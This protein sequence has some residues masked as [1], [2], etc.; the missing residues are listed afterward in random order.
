MAGC[1]GSGTLS[2]ATAPD[3]AYVVNVGQGKRMTA[4]LLGSLDGG[5]TSWDSVFNLVDSVASCGSMDTSID[6]GTVGISCLAGVDNPPQTVRVEN[7]GPAKDYFLLVDGYSSGQGGFALDVA[8]TDLPTPIVGGD[9]C[10]N[11]VTLTPS[12]TYLA[13]TDGGASNYAFPSLNG[14]ATTNNS[15]DRSF[16]I[17]VPPMNSATI[18]VT[19][20]SNFNPV[21][22]VTTA[23]ANCGSLGADGGTQG[24]IC[25]GSGSVG[26][27]G[28][29]ETVT[30]NNVSANP[31]TF[32]IIVD[33]STTTA[34]ARAGSFEI[35]GTLTQLPALLAGGESCGTAVNLPVGSFTGT[36]TGAANDYSFAA[37][38]SCRLSSAAGDV[39]YAITVPANGRGL[40][41]VS[42]LTSGFTP[43]VNL[44]ANVAN[45]GTIGID[46]GTQGG[47]CLR[48]NVDKATISIGNETGS[49]VTYF[50]VV[51]STTAATGDFRITYATEA[52]QPSGEFCSAPEIIAMNG[53]LTGT[54]TGYGDDVQTNSAAAANCGGFSNLGVDRVYQVTLN[55]GEQ[56]S[57]TVTPTGAS[58]DPGLYVVDSPA[59]NCRLMGTTCLT[60]SDVGGGGEP[61]SISYL[62]NS[63]ASKTVF[64]VIDNYA[65]TSSGAYSL[66]VNVG[67]PPPPPYTKTA[68][69]TANCIDMTSG[70]S[71][72]SV[73]ADDAA[74]SVTALPVGFDFQFFGGA[75]THFSMTS[76]GFMQL[77][78]SSIGSPE[79]VAANAVIPTTGAPNNI[80]A[81]FW[82]DLDNVAGT[83]ARTLVSGT[84]GS[85]VFTVQWG[86]F[87][88]YSASGPQPERLTFQIQLFEGTDVIE[89]H[90]CSLAANGGNAARVGGSE[91]TVGVENSTGTVGIP[92]SFDTAASVVSGT[93]LRFTPP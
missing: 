64:L 37:T 80:V 36:T 65:A 90:Y 74:S 56:L 18:V 50:V 11:A 44:V 67:P 2:S 38:A 28:T 31:A 54:T 40:V 30:V 29:A 82:D 43:S 17:D 5:D 83:T 53:T 34:S 35:T 23:V 13:A 26:G 19:P 8:I 58:W 1:Q 71:L 63:G 49:D 69:A 92:H 21:V 85:R 55:S 33:A 6:G 20:S 3:R 51:D 87:S 78:A 60:G 47:S 62:N 72:S 42:S 88:I 52:N 41:T 10:A 75:V 48:N 22:N 81:A 25:L 66:L 45:C 59:A 93:G 32:N 70:T 57:A 86:G 15:P 68:I 76:N 91:A 84:S 7:P 27:T 77:Y 73:V 12:T 16:K 24:G 9:T 14:C 79:V 89:I 61:D 46:A 39:A 4:R